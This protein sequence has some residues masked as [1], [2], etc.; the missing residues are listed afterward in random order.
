[1][2]SGHRHSPMKVK[3]DKQKK[4]KIDKKIQKRNDFDCNSHHQPSGD[5]GGGDTN[6]FILFYFIYFLV[7]SFIGKQ[8]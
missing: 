7:K 1:M 8:F 6:T 4:K 2:F 3:M 5:T